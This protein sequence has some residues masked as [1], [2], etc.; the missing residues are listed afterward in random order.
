LCVSYCCPACT[1][2]QRLWYTITVVRAVQQSIRRLITGTPYPLALQSLISLVLLATLPSALAE[3]GYLLSARFAL[4]CALVGLALAVCWLVPVRKLGVSL[5]LAYL[6][7]QVVATSLAHMVVP[8]QLLGYVYLVIVLQ[9]VYLFKPLVWILFAV[10]AYTLWSGSLMIASANLIEWTRGN[11]ALAFPVLCILIAAMVYARQHQRS[12][13][14]QQVLQQMQ[15]RYDTLLL[16]LRDAQQRATIE[17]RQRLTQTIAHDIAAALGQIEQS[18]ANAISQA[19]TSLP[20]F[21]T[22]VAQTR[23]AATSA[24]ERLRSAVAT[25]RS[26][27]DDQVAEPH[28]ALML[29]LA[30]LMTVRSQRWLT[31]CLPLAFA[32]IVLP[33]TL[34]Q[35]PVTPA[36]VAVFILSCAALAIGYIFTQ[37]I[38]NTL[39]VQLGL[40]GQVLA[41]LGIVF[42]TQALP[43]TFGLL[44]VMWQMALRLSAGQIVTF[45]VGLQTM[46]GLVL[47]RVLPVPAVD[48]TQ[49]LIF[50]VACAAVI[51]LVGP[52]RRQLSKRRQAE[53][54]LAQ[55][56]RSADE[57]EQQVAQVSALGVAIER[58]RVAREIHD[59]L[60]HRLVLLNVQLQLVDE[61][62]AEDPAAALNQLC[63]TRE[64][65]HEAWSSVLGTADLALA[66]DG[67]TLV[68]A[69]DRLVDQCRTLTLMR[70]TLRIIGDLAGFNAALACAIYRA[71]QEGL[72][73][74]YK[75][76][77]AQQADVI[78]YCDD[79]VVQVRV[80]DDG[81]GTGTSVATEIVPGAAG[82]FGLV[83]LR[84][85]AELLGG[86]V[87]AGSRP[88]SGFELIMS[89]PI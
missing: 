61:L 28:P 53:T 88:E 75:Y 41:V 87:E 57:L 89:I 60:G 80:R 9:A 13:H 78:V 27:R 25:L 45:L 33:L 21:E 24:I 56:A 10:G 26:T 40:A 58:T 51:G 69:L 6:G 82:H 35:H 74:T 14:A 12:E 55:L 48:Q 72:T 84:E 59:D 50:G 49:L 76:A 8:S 19:Q 67:T 7:L 37:R 22:T 73:N 36:L 32:A 85:R 2:D 68:P 71:V 5:Q 52:A 18:I 62:I 3:S 42:T 11:L 31:W 30:E 65:L 70:I 83:G 46:I 4:L 16:H 47:T 23:A 86:S 20:R 54:R 44:L 63:S 43:L 1:T 17:E 77:Q 66:L 79:V 29:P 15:Q 34:L 38:R 64:Q 39:L 81:H